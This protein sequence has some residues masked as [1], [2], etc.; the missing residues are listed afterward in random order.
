MLFLSADF[1]ASAFLQ[2]IEIC[3]GRS[4][5]WG[6]QWSV[7]RGYWRV[8]STET[9]S[10]SYRRST[11]HRTNWRRGMSG[12][13][14]TG[15]S[16]L[17]HWIHWWRWWGVPFTMWCFHRLVITICQSQTYLLQL[18]Q[19]CPKMLTSH[20]ILNCIHSAS[21]LAKFL[22]WYSNCQVW[23]TAWFASKWADEFGLRSDL[24]LEWHDSGS[25]GGRT[26]NCS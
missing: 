19:S 5:D 4:R 3:A 22:A 13:N 16:V 1:A 25:R 14:R 7:S 23:M 10:P 12:R 9:I 21:H 18:L 8:E 26:A 24:S 6:V 17:T 20:F 2:P 11:S 15:Q